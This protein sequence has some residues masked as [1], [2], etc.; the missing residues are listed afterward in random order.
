MYLSW[1]EEFAPAMM[2]KEGS[3]QSSPDRSASGQGGGSRGQL[4]IRITARKDFPAYTLR[5]YT[6]RCNGRSLPLRTLHPG[7][8]QELTIDL[9]S[10]PQGG[11]TE[12]SLV[13]PGGF[14]ILKKV[15]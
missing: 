9:S 14:V 5:D 15:F 1:Q 7:E 10:A 11:P 6:I 3:S 13:K 2:E 8:S 4:I 12:V